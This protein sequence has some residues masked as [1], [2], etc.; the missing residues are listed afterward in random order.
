[1]DIKKVLEATNASFI[2]LSDKNGNIIDSVHTEYE[3]NFALMTEAAFS[4]CSD[5]LK[6]IN[7]SNLK[8]IMAKSDNDYFIANKIEKDEKILLIGS[9]DLSKLGLHLKYMNSL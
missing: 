8:Q 9:N 4:M 6:D 3:D 5:L 1:M 7:N 2:V